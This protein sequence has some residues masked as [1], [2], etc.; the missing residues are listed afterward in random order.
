MIVPFFKEQRIQEVMIPVSS[1][2]HSISRGFYSCLR[3]PCLPARHLQAEACPL[4]LLKWGKASQFHWVWARFRKLGLFSPK[5]GLTT[6]WTYFNV[7]RGKERFDLS[8]KASQV[9]WLELQGSSLGLVCERELIS[10]RWQVPVIGRLPHPSLHTHIRERVPPRPHL[11][12]RGPDDG[13]NS[14]TRRSISLGGLKGPCWLW[15]LPFWK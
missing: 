15:E 14:Y 2:L 6:V 13:G 8:F 3:A 9:W 10:K 12:P 11:Q 5:K 1:V 4:G 7:C